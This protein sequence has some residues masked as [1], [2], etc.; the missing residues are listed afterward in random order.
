MYAG[1]GGQVTEP[2]TAIYIYIS[3]IKSFGAAET[4]Q[5]IPGRGAVIYG[6]T[7]PIAEV[8][9][10]YIYIYIFVYRMLY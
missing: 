2:E 10:K 3:H 7:V 9:P 8:V 4:Y 6:G 5:N 1:V